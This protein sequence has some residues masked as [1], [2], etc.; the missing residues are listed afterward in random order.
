MNHTDNVRQIT[1]VDFPY[2]INKRITKNYE[3]YRKNILNLNLIE[4]TNNN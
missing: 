4:H 2:K 1:L 3:K